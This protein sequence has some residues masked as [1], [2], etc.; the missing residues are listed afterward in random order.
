MVKTYKIT[1]KLKS[2]T[3]FNS[4]SSVD[5]F[6]NSKIYKDQEGYPYIPAKHFLG[7]LK[8]DINNW[9]KPSSTK[10]QIETIEEILEGKSDKI[11]VK[12]SDFMINQEV[13]NELQ[14]FD[15]KYNKKLFLD[16]ENEFNVDIKKSELLIENRSLIKTKNIKNNYLN[17]MEIITSGTVFSGLLSID[18]YESEQQEYIY[19]E[20]GRYMKLVDHIGTKKNRGFGK[21]EVEIDQVN[22][23]SLISPRSVNKNS[24]WILYKM[25][26]ESPMKLISENGNEKFKT[27]TTYVPSSAMK[28]AYIGN[29][30]K[31]NLIKENEIIE[32][33]KTSSFYNA[34]PM[35]QSY[36]AMPTPNIYRVSQNDLEKLK[37][38][39][40]ESKYFINGL[41]GKSDSEKKEIFCTIFDQIESNSKLTNKLEKLKYGETIEYKPGEYFYYEN[42][43][44]HGFDVKKEVHSR[45]NQQNND[46]YQYEV[47]S[48]NQ[49]YYGLIKLGEMSEKIKNN[50]IEM[51]NT[52]S[53]LSL[54]SHKNLGYG[55][56]KITEIMGFENIKD[57]ELKLGIERE[58]IE[59]THENYIYS[60]FDLCAD[61]K[62]KN[63]EILISGDKEIKTAYNRKLQSM[64]PS[65]E[66][67]Q[68]GSVI[69]SK[70]NSE[71]I[72]KTK[73][74][75]DGYNYLIENPKF[76]KASA[77][78][79]EKM[80]LNNN[81]INRYEGEEVATDFLQK[82]KW[83]YLKT[84]TDKKVAKYIETIG[85]D[86]SKEF[87]ENL[88][89]SAYFNL[90]EI[91]EVLKERLFNIKWQN[92]FNSMAKRNQLVRADLRIEL[93]DK[94]IIGN[95][96]LYDL[97]KTKENSK[98]LENSKEMRFYNDIKKSGEELIKFILNTYKISEDYDLNYYIESK[99]LYTIL[100]QLFENTERKA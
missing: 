85:V 35:F 41:F 75:W 46:L 69:Q 83:N 50:F 64:I 32:F 36:Y 77:I 5:G 44:L 74:N 9:L 97:L 66:V 33:I 60:Y 55:Q 96:N 12:W 61:I 15:S 86:L 14:K 73:N 95:L 84:Y 17:S 40:D 76:L 92:K 51:L 26:L 11:K 16:N 24:N 22:G 3:C 47:L 27:S 34:Y 23:S 37:H 81:L 56:V 48:A 65:L 57:L 6:E 93:G 8:S 31:E 80:I 1:I 7:V 82:I 79:T 13:Y 45:K 25:N 54:G 98:N 28:G 53:K 91:Y 100:D 71:D 59:P 18:G 67:Y 19:K 20:L 62:D 72:L 29:L 39:G 89:H 99:L 58:L 90:Y 49:S 2:D 70:D 30:I 43:T 10:E 87:V 63:K 52:I 78:K 4:N 21:V 94:Y 42:D 38:Q 88:S 68:R